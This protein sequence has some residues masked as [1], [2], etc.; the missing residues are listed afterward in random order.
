MKKIIALLLALT[1]VFAMTACGNSTTNSGT[2]DEGA[3]ISSA[4]ETQE[5]EQETGSETTTDFPSKNITMI[6]P[7]DLGGGSDLIARTL[8]AEMENALG[9][10]IICENV[11]GGSTSIGLQQLADSNPDGYTIALSMT[12]LAALSTLG[13]S[14][15][16]R[17]DFESIAAV[18][19]DAATVLIRTDE[20]RFTDLESLIAY[21]QA[22]PG[23]L[24]WGTGAAGG[25]WHLAI[26]T[27]CNAADIE[28]NIVPDA[29][30][31]TGVGQALAN[32]DVDVA[33]FSPVDCMSQI[34]AG[35]I[36]PIVSMTEE[37]M[38]SFQEVPTA[39]ELG[40]DITTLS[41]RG[42][43]AP[44]GTPDEVIDVLEDAVKKAVESD[45]YKEFISSMASNIYWLDSQ[46]Y[47]NFM[48]EEVELYVPL[49]E[50]AGL[51]Q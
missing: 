14:E 46:E 8:A 2:S 47:Y 28:V 26:L 11:T 21:A 16:T 35:E 13:Y 38:E 15:L 20:D 49:L 18:N 27:L 12:N 23:E 30:G 3:E 5:S 24:N 45:S 25:M 32:G 37:R 39:I 51:A 19:Y 7:Q 31:G 6:I 43:L 40:Y 4:D 22:H 36:T 34:E 42:F 17:D 9:V 10:S 29:G 48:G 33:V 41:T 44:K 1:M 50:Q